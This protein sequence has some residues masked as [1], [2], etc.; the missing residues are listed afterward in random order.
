MPKPQNP[1]SH[2]HTIWVDTLLG[3]ETQKGLVQI[4][5]GTTSVQLQPEEAEDLAKN[6]LQAA[7]ATRSEEFLLR[8]LSQGKALTLEQK[9]A[10]IIA[11]RKFRGHEAP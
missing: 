3:G 11:L 4:S 1:K 2:E 9:G 5:F 7:E 8:F 10:I 6:L